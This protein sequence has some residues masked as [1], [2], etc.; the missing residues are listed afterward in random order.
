MAASGRNRSALRTVLIRMLMVFKTRLSQ[1]SVTVARRAAA[2]GVTIRV[3][4]AARV[5]ERVGRA[6]RRRDGHA[7]RCRGGHGAGAPSGPLKTDRRKLLFRNSRIV[8]LTCC[9]TDGL[10]WRPFLAVSGDS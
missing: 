9:D 4:H 1:G 5:A 3:C 6:A 10:C 8:L 2:D 7:G